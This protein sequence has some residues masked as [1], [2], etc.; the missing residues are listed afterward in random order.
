MYPQT[1]V[2]NLTRFISVV[3]FRPLTWRN[4][5]PYVLADR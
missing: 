2:N 1:E 3:K 4:T 5:H